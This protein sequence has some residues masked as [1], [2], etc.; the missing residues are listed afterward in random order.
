DEKGDR[1]R[2][3]GEGEAIAILAVA[4]EQDPDLFAF[5]RSLEAY[6]SFLNSNT[7]LVLPADSPLFQFLQD[8]NGSAGN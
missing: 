2:G 3:E 7:T 8:P 1:L 4:L 6:A 5:R